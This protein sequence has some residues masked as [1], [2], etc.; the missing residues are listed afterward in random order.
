MTLALL[1]FACGDANPIGP[2]NQPEIG[3]N[4]DNFQFQ[5]SNLSGTTQTLS[6]S[7]QHTGTIANVN[8]SGAVSAGD[9]RLILTDG[10]GNAVYDAD[11]KN[12]GT[13]MSS[14]GTAGTWRI[15]VRLRDVTGTLNFRLQKRS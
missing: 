11:L 4:T 5:A 14:S 7:W 6:Y 12:T 10:A 3:N 15:G 2:S 1:A 9:A 13:F 8:Q